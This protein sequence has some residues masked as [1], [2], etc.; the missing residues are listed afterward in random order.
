MVF[1]VKNIIPSAPKEL[2][3]VRDSD[4]EKV[5]KTMIW[6]NNSTSLLR[7]FYYPKQ[8]IAKMGNVK[9]FL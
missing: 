8:N 4:E 5:E 7:Y 2:V 6:T 3:V 1:I 9:E